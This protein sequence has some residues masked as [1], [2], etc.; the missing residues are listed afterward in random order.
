MHQVRHSSYDDITDKDF[1]IRYGF[2]YQRNYFCFPTILIFLYWKW[3]WI[4]YWKNLTWNVLKTYLISPCTIDSKQWI[5]FCPISVSFKIVHIEYSKFV[6]A[7]K[8]RNSSISWNLKRRLQNHPCHEDRRKR[9]IEGTRRKY[10]NKK[11]EM[12]NCR[13]QRSEHQRKEKRFRHKFV[14]ILGRWLNPITI[15]SYLATC[16]HK[17]AAA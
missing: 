17:E 4:Q 9:R 7:S 14:L 1:L 13:H 10:R 15:T 3:G 6:D 8:F 12:E 16:H 2:F 11:I 5:M